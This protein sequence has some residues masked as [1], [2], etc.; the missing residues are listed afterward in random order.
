M[1]KKSNLSRRRFISYAGAG[2]AMAVT[3]TTSLIGTSVLASKVQRGGTITLSVPEPVA[4]LDP[5]KVVSHG[6]FPATFHMFSAL[7]RIGQDFNAKP[8]LAKSWSTLDGGQTWTFNLFE[9]AKFHNGRP[10]TAEDVKYS[11]ERVL[12]EKTSPHGHTAIGPIKEV[13]AK[14]LHT[15]E[16]R[17]TTTYVDLPVDL[18]GIYPRVVDRENI[19][20]IY[21]APNGSGPFKMVKWEPNGITVLAANSDYHITGEDGQAIPYIDSMRLVPIKEPTSEFAALQSGE[22]DIMFQLPYDL[23]PAAKG[24][25]K[26]VVDATETG[27]HNLSLHQKPTFRLPNDNS[28]LLLDKRVRQAI[29]YAINRPAILDVSIGG[30]GR[31]GNDQPIPP[32]HVY[33]HAGLKPREHNV[34]KSKQLLAEAG[35]KP[36][37]RLILHTTTG[38]PGL[39]EHALAV[40]EM[41][42]EVGLD[43]AVDAIDISRYWT[44][45]EYRAPMYMD[46]W[47]AR[48]TINASI[49][50]FYE[51]GGGNNCAGFSN[52]NVDSLLS[53]AEGETDFESR[54]SLYN[55]AMEIIS[56]EAVTIIPYFKGYYI[57]MNP[58]VG[59]VSA[60]PMSYMW[61]DWAY[62]KA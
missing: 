33:G 59:G 47:G 34:E 39:M 23:I 9:N 4:E 13:I 19:D 61:L 22:T 49:K 16:I 3:G 56:D 46:N 53:R 54:K 15:V 17:L 26:I 40:R 51:T 35:V 5:H 52:A 62:R 41:A 36:G 30:F 1:I 43:I 37:T 7:T 21:T 31:I 38:R 6:S 20:K 8:E 32:T 57:A 50:P 44:D 11:L 58:A 10:V 24:D 29:A 55:Q 42:K 18:G 25:P 28:E 14:G 12:D 48:Q 60:H 27:Y 45:I 2:A